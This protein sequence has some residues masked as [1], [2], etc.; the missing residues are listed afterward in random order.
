MTAQSGDKV[1]I[2]FKCVSC[3]NL[4]GRVG[5]SRG[6]GV[7]DLGPIDEVDPTQCPRCGSDDTVPWGLVPKP[8]E[9]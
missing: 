9:D 3:L 5:Q 7:I 6:K 2:L 8:D 4:F 1:A